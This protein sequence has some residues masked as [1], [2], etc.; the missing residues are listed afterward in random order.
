MIVSFQFLSVMQAWP[1]LARHGQMRKQIYYL[2]LGF[3]RFRLIERIK[4]QCFI[5][6]IHNPSNFYILVRQ[7]NKTSPRA[8]AVNLFLRTKP[9]HRKIA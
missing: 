9:S 1:W 7:F 2:A 8:L 6:T 4:I 5:S 3:V